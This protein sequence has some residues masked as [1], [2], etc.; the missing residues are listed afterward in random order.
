MSI[1]RFTVTAAFLLALAPFA[2]FL[3][4]GCESKPS[5]PVFDNGFDPEGPLLGDPLDVRATLGDTAITVIWTEPQ[6]YNISFYEVSHSSTY[7]SGYECVEAVAHT[8]TGLGL[9]YYPHPEPTAPHY[10]RVVAMKDDGSYMLASYQTPAGLTTPPNVVLGDG[11]GSTATRH[12]QLAITVSTGDQLLIA[13]NEQFDNALQ[14]AVVEPGVAQTVDWDLGLADSNRVWF[15]FYVQAL[16][17]TEESEVFIDSLRVNFQPGFTVENGAATVA[18]SSVTLTIPA[19]GVVQMRFASSSEALAGATW[20]T[21]AAEL[22]AFELIDTLN[23]QTV[24]G[25]FVGDFGFNSPVMEAD[26]AGDPLTDISFAIDLA[27]DIT[28]DPVLVLLCDATATQVR[29]GESPDFETSAWRDYAD[30][31]DFTLST[32][33]GAKTIYAQFRNDFVDSELLSAE[34]E[35]IEQPLAVGFLAPLDGQPLTAGSSQVMRGWADA[36]GTAEIDSVK[37]ELGDGAGFVNVIGTESW[38]LP[39]AAPALADTS[40]DADAEELILR[41]RAWSGV[42]TATAQITVTIRK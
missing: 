42:D 34:I 17:G 6:G 23:P 38:E 29:F 26:V 8:G 31:L 14:I 32:G 3:L 35:Y 9:A 7:G 21:G 10:F 4:G 12:I 5:E 41:A 19:D 18:T 2:F 20:L 28:N 22:P 1:R 27:R 11:S 15:P 40:A 24:Y 16:D 13:D 37:V 30:T 33:S 25:E 36:T 39:W